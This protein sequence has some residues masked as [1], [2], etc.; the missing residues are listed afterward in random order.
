[1]AMAGEE[2]TI[3]K[4]APNTGAARER[5]LHLSET[6]RNRI[7]LLDY[8]P[9]ERLGEEALAAEFGVS[10]TPLRRALVW[11]E[12]QGLVRSVQGVGT[13]VTDVDIADLAQVYHLR[14]ELANMIGR[15]APVP[16][17]E[18][19]LSLFADIRV[20]GR[21]LA[22][23]P[24]PRIFAQLNIDFF[25]VIMK[26]TGNEPLRETSER[27]FY[28]TSRIWLKS[29]PVLDFKAEVDQF[30]HEIED[31]GAAV[32]LGD[33]DAV[34]NLRR[35]HISMSVARLIRHHEAAQSGASE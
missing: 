22:R 35:A 19:T 3:V 1:M 20:R 21:A 32:A 28:Q 16:P 26:L 5:F 14:M 11:L 25:H 18:R 6:L 10:R 27:Y 7:C 23:K 8:A 12:S 31:I 33:L 24:D 17:N 29:I 13:I 2:E 34:G 30:C 15:V 4:P 9:G